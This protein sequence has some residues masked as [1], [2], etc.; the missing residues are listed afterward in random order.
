[1]EIRKKNT[2]MI[3]TKFTVFFLA[4]IAMLC[5]A[6]S[7]AAPSAARKL[8]QRSAIEGGANAHDSHDAEEGGII[9][10][11]G[12]YACNSTLT[13]DEM[14]DEIVAALQTLSVATQKVHVW[15]ASGPV[16]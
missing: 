12:D 6:R 7:S 3:F 15:T 9:T 4:S 1:M 2:N 10:S 8:F 14:R 5:F 11:S 13:E 16:R